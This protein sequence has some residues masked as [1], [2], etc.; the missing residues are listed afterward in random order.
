MKTE[1]YFVCS[2]G[3]FAETP[4][5]AAEREMRIVFVSQL[6]ATK[7]TFLAGAA[8]RIADFLLTERDMITAQFKQADDFVARYPQTIKPDGAPVPLR[9]QAP[10]Q[11]K[12]TAAA[13]PAMGA[14]TL[15]KPA[16]T[17]DFDLDALDKELRASADR[18][19][20]K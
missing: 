20:T 9:R 3:T 4:A 7:D 5:L 19:V 8:E 1:N 12:I 17:P 13:A 14:P 11:P 10:A 16:S 6:V 2:D 18:E 15:A